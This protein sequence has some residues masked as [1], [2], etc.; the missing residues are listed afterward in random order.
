MPFNGRPRATKGL[1]APQSGYPTT[2]MR[3]VRSEDWSRRLV[4]EN[5]L[6]VDDLIWPVFVHGGT[7]PRIPV[8]TMPGTVRYSVDALGEAAKEAADLGIP[9]I[10]VFPQVDAE[11][12]D[13]IGTYAVTDNNIVCQ[14]VQAVKSE[15]PSIGVMCDAALDPFTDHGHDGLLENGAIQ[16]DATVEVLVQQAV[17]QAKAGCDVISPSDM[18]DGRVG[19]IRAGLDA[20]GFEHVMIM[21]YAAKY[22]SGFYGPFRDAVGS[23]S[24][25]GAASKSTY[26]MDP[27]NTD[28]AIREV[29]LDIAE[30]ADMVMVKPGMPYLDI[31]RRVKDAFGVPTFAY[32]VSGEYAMLKAAADNG[33][34][35]MDR[36]MPESLMAFK[37]AGADGI[38]TY[39]AIEMAKRLRG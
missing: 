11:L 6:S 21:S 25:L 14:A 28:E 10:A 26:Q 30:G 15:A 8:E 29:A 35:D 36:V 37:R 24:T 18:M 22:A 4:R 3:R 19:A 2:R 27:A 1:V 16:N 17:L 7:E 13:G 12:K 5:Q 20:A 39:F 38:L 31:L 33:W 9:V 32:Q 34:L 23:A